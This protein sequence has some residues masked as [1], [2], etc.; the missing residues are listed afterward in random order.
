VSS[1]V[2][3]FAINGDDFCM[4]PRD[5]PT[6]CPD[7][8]SKIGIDR[9]FGHEFSRDSITIDGHADNVAECGGK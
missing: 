4:I 5:T 2:E 9:Q 6:P 3:V 8:E 7:P 1:G